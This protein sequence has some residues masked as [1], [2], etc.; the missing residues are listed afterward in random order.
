MNINVEYKPNKRQALFHSCAADEVV[1]G[2]ARGGGKSCALVMESLAYGL[3]HPGANMYI[4]RESYKDLEE[5]IIKEFKDKVPPQ[6]YKYN[7]STHVATLTNG[8]TI[9]FTYCSSV[10]EARGY[11]GRNIDWL[12]VDELTFHTE[13]EIQ[14]LLGCVRSAK[15]YP[16][17]FRAT[18]NPGGIGHTWV[19][20]RYILATKYGVKTWYDK[21]TQNT[22]AFIPA[23]VY[24]NDALMKNDPKYVKRLENMAENDKQAYLYGNWD[25]FEGQYF[26]EFKRDIHV[27]KPFDIP[28]W[29]QKFISLDYGLDC[30]AAL[31]YA[32]DG[33]GRP[34]VYKELAVNGLTYSQAAKSILEKNDTDN[35]SYVVASPDLWN[36]QRESGESGFELM[37]RSGLHSIIR[38]NNSRIPGWRTLKEYLLPFNDEY[39]KER[40]KLAIFSNCEELIRCLPLLQFDKKN[41]EDVSSKP[42][43][44]THLPESLRYGIM[45]RPMSG[46]MP[47]F[48]NPDPFHLREEIAEGVTGEISDDYIYFGVD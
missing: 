17:L 37:I 14:L 9:T 34:Y 16:A 46:T 35:Y 27:W 22:I 31:W 24:D 3:E 48:E 45:S 23:T 43:D 32:V 13:Q 1:Y 12:G 18:C 15:G 5:N 19:K 4:F 47:I 28:N 6:L 41:P 29:W 44:I 11:N 26:G 25:I 21:D 33:Q 2:G 36:R 10:D 7:S 39:S 38:A 40:A 30:T 8:A 20:N 42:H